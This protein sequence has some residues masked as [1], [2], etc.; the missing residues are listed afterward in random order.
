MNAPR[1][2]ETIVEMGSTNEG[3]DLLL[4]FRF[5]DGSI[6]PFEMAHQ[7][8]GEF[9][10]KLVFAADAANHARLEAA[11]R[12]QRMEPIGVMDLLDFQVQESQLEPI[13]ILRMTIGSGIHVGFGVALAQLRPIAERLLAVAARSGV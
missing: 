11:G 10:G 13:A 7:R 4:G 9:I 3:R 8:V 12:V 5:E 1:R 2:I 6:E